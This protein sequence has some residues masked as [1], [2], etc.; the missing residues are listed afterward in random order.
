MKK[1]ISVLLILSLI[2]GFV[3]CQSQNNNNDDIPPVS[4]KPDPPAYTASEVLTK[5]DFIS[6]IYTDSDGKNLPFRIYLPENYNSDYAYP[7]LVFLHGAGERGDD[8]D[9]QLKNVVMKLFED[10]SSPIY[11]CILIAPQ[12]P[13]E[14]QWVDTPWEDGNYSVDQIPESDQLRQ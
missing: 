9:L 3:G 5:D 12:C 1:I 6:D 7:L 4:Q 2:L 11:Q 13:V 14:E 10:K 8:N